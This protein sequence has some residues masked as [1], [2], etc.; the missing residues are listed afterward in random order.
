MVKKTAARQSG[1]DQ[2]NG[3]QPP[4]I[5]QVAD[6]RAT[7][8]CLKIFYHFSKIVIKPN[9][10]ERNG[11]LLPPDPSMSGMLG[12]RPPTPLTINGRLNSIER[13]N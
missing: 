13:T 7:V 4:G 11:T 6:Q 2:K 5:A 1:Q 9:L 3:A 10:I 12:Y 8:E